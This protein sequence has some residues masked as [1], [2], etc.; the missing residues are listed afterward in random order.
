MILDEKS[1]HLKFGGWLF[2]LVL[3]KEFKDFAC[4]ACKKIIEKHE[5]VDFT[6]GF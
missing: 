2:L 4:F 5:N 1:T 3:Q 6:K